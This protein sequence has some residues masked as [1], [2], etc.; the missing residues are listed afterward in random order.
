[1]PT[2]KDRS[3]LRFRTLPLRRSAL[4]RRRTG[5]PT[6]QPCLHREVLSNPS[7][8]RAKPT[9][10]DRCVPVATWLRRVGIP[11]SCFAIYK[12]GCTRLPADALSV[13]FLLVPHRR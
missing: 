10:P 5:G 6:V 2:S 7:S 3:S 4:L 1:M 8:S 11:A 13:H 9:Y 12:I